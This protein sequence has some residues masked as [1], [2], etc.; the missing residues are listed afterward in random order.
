MNLYLIEPGKFPIR[1]LNTNEINAEKY[2]NP[3]CR[4]PSVAAARP[5]Q[6]PAVCRS[7]HVAEARTQ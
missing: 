4:S 2:F 6:Q 3:V 1:R 5:S 7:P